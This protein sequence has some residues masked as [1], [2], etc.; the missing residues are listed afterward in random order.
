MTGGAFLL[1][2]GSDRSKWRRAGYNR[3]HYYRRT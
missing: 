1:G 3:T 2:D